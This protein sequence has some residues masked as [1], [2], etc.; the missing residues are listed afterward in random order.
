MKLVPCCM[1]VV[2]FLACSPDSSS[3]VEPVSQVCY[4]GQRWV[5]GV[6]CV[7]NAE[8]ASNVDSG[9]TDGGADAD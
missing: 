2:T 7:D 4:E 5:K 6:G 8:R 1:V 9:V 3:G